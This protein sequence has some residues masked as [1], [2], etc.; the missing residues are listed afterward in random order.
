MFEATVDACN[1][2]RHKLVLGEVKASRLPGPG[3]MTAHCFSYLTIFPIPKRD[4]V[5]VFEGYKP[6]WRCCSGSRKAAVMLFFT[7]RKPVYKREG[8]RAS[9]Q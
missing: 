6:V 3:S 9:E 7:L 8:W 2:L 4:Y 5:A 1:L